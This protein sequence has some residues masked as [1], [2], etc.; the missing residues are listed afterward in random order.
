MVLKCPIPIHT[1]ILILG[2]RKL[3]DLFHHLTRLHLAFSLRNHKFKLVFKNQMH[4][5]DCSRIQ[6]ALKSEIW[7]QRRDWNLS[8]TNSLWRAGQGKRKCKEETMVLSKRPVNNKDSRRGDRKSRRWQGEKQREQKRCA[9]CSLYKY[10][11]LVCRAL[12]VGGLYSWNAT[13]FVFRSVFSEG[14]VVKFGREERQS[15]VSRPCT[16]DI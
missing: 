13:L 5:D 10:I 8:K 11:Y 1:I 14:R 4:L 15:R 6:T 12:V 7:R 16:Y 3:R 2:Y 9:S